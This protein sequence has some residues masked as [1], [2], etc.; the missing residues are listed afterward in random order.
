MLEQTLSSEHS[1]DGSK[2]G[3]SRLSFSESFS[4]S[5]SHIGQG[6]FALPAASSDSQLPIHSASVPAPVMSPVT[7]HAVLPVSKSTGGHPDPDSHTGVE[8][9]VTQI[10]DRKIDG[11]FP[12]T[13][14][15][16]DR[17]RNVIDPN[18]GLGHIDRVLGKDKEKKESVVEK[19][20]GSEHGHAHGT[21]G[22]E[23]CVE[24]R[25]A[26]KES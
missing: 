21:G 13:K 11:G 9:Q 19:E 1:G 5:L 22:K 24:C 10:W 20:K 12:E 4:S 25:D 26:A 3:K 6:P 23:D 2:K 8:V 7:A 17:V 15:L 14:E 18:R 16:K